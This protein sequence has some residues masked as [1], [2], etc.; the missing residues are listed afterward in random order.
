M[1]WNNF[2][3]LA[4]GIATGGAV[5]YGY[6]YM[7]KAPAGQQSAL[8]LGPA[9]DPKAYKPFVLSHVEDI[10]HDTRR[11]RFKFD[12]PNQLAGITV[13][14][15][16]LA[17]YQKA[18]KQYVVQPYTP[19][20]LPDVK[21][22]IELVVK[23]YP[24][25]NMSGYF[26]NLKAGDTVEMMGPIT[27]LPIQANM[28]EA[29]GMVAGGTGITPMYQVIQEVL[30]QPGNKMKLT[31]LYGSKS[32]NDILLKDEL[33][34]LAQAHPNLFEVHYIVDQAGPSWKG[35]TGHITS[36]MLKQHLPPPSDSNM[37]FVCGPPGMMRSVSGGKQSPKDQGELTGALKTLGYTANQVFKF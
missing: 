15:C 14:S 1:G 34:S 21:G 33:D 17:R 23:T 26:G 2:Q 22:Y 4:A 16:L 25:G 30:R 11:Y 27:K 5:W 3:K 31:L 7:R 9:L 37:V 32:E 19:T 8:V 13:A 10:S 12:D 24:N 36:D 29:I 18:D 20:T 28:K 6:K 35:L